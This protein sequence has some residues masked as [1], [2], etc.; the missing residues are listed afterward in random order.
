MSYTIY[1]HTNKINGKRY[2]GVTR[3]NPRDRWGNGK[4]YTRHGRF[5]LDIQ[6]YGWEE[7]AHE[8]LFTDLSKE[9]ASTKEAELVK[10]WKLTDPKHGYNYFAG[11]KI[12]EPSESAKRKLSIKNMGVNNPF[13]GRHHEEKTKRL[14]AKLK[15]KT[16]V[17]CVETGEIYESFRE[18][19]RATGA[20]HSDIA[21]CIRGT[22]NRKIAG[23]FH[24]EY[25]EGRK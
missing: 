17:K 18:A 15:S 10:K 21:K 25:A 8:I 5:Y 13:Y 20:Y 3:Q 6:K 1:C 16:C 14:M 11:G 12:V 2:V 7:F 23:G 9:E 19:E 4:H 22:K 24:W